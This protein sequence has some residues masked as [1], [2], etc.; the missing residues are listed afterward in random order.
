[1]IAIYV[2]VY[3]NY[4]YAWEL[5]ATLGYIRNYLE[6]YVDNDWQQYC[7]CIHA[8]VDADAEVTAVDAARNQHYFPTYI[9][10]GNYST[11]EKE[12]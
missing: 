8:D 2:Y 3:I 4:Y 5:H 11:P 9:P 1:M 10:D 12:Y 7:L 6:N